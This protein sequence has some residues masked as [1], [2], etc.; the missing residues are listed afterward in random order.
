MF[1]EY[2]KKLK[3]HAKE[4]NYKIEGLIWIYPLSKRK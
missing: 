1:D 2:E 3:K 4:K